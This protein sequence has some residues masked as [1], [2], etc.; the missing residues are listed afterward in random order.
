MVGVVHVR[1]LVVLVVNV[2]VHVHV[3]GHVI[4]H[5]SVS[6]NTVHV[7]VAVDIIEGGHYGI[8]VLGCNG[9]SQKTQHLDKVFLQHVKKRNKRK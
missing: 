2:I 5:S 4:G 1:P 8:L 6:G 7:V 3:H 9:K